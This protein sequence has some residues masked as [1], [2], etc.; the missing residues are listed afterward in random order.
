VCVSQKISDRSSLLIL[1]L[2]KSSL[3]V[4]TGVKR[5]T[6]VPWWGVNFGGNFFVSVVDPGPD[7]LL[8]KKINILSLEHSVCKV[9]ERLL[10]FENNDLSQSEKPDQSPQPVKVLSYTKSRIKTRVCWQDA[11]FA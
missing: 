4:L 6:L 10:Q 2:S 3:T 8:D 5:A 11:N 1:L 9:D 7:D